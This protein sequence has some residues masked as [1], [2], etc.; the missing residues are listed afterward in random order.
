MVHKKI[1]KWVKGIKE[2][3]F[4]RGL[5]LFHMAEPQLFEPAGRLHM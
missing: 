3:V 1:K 4:K 5:D 2:Q